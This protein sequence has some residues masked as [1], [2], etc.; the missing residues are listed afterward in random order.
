MRPRK[1]NKN[2][3]KNEERKFFLN[4][5]KATHGVSERQFCRDNKLA[6]STW[7]GE[8]EEAPSDEDVEYF[9]FGAMEENGAEG[10]AVSKA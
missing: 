10:I 3:Y 2:R 5:F 6:F 7:Q 1:R 8:V 4:K 9:T